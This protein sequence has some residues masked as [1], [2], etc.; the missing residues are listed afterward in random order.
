MAMKRLVLSAVCALALG[1]CA[2][3]VSYGPAISPRASGFTEQRI[4][5]DRF[6]VTFR[7]AGQGAQINDFALLRASELTLQQ[8]FEWF[9]IVGRSEDVGQHNGPRMSVGTG[10]T[11][12][13][14]RSAV[15]VGIGT[16]FDLGGGP[17]REV[18][19]EIKMGAGPTP[20]DRDVYDARSVM[21][22]VRS[23]M[24]PPPPR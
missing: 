24:G 4:E 6:R 11:N 14:R 19:L 3:P 23:R 8:G 1:A 22:S 20:N 13:G 7:G 5:N 17:M 21:T 2:T 18:A 10:S 9:R 15:G 12:Y 16:S